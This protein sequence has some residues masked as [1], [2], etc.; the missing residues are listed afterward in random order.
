MPGGRTEFRETSGQNLE[1]QQLVV[2]PQPNRAGVCNAQGFFTFP[3]I[4]AGKW[5]VMTSIV[6][7]AGDSYQGGTMLSSAEVRDGQEIEIV[8]SQ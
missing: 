5:Y 2:P 7:T 1:N 4:R 8:I 6:W 3:N